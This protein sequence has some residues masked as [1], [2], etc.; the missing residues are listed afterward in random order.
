VGEDEGPRERPFVF[1]LRT[2]AADS[3]VLPGSAVN[4]RNPRALSVIGVIKTRIEH[5]RRTDRSSVR[6]TGDGV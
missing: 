2:F 3:V 4:E 6:Q 5:T 1:L